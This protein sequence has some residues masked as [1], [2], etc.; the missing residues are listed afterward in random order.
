[1]S[2]RRPLAVEAP[3]K[4]NRELRVGPRRADGFHDIRSRFASIA[5]ADRIEAEEGG[6]LELYCDTPGIPTDGT[7]LV[8]RAALGLADRLGVAPRAR[9]RLTK[10]VPAGAGLGGG[11]SDAAA[12]LRL[13]SRLW[14]RTLPEAEISLLAASL[15]SDVPYFLSGGEA[16][17]SG[18]GETVA[19]RADAT[20]RDLLL[21]V[22]PFPISTAEVY[23]A[24]DRLGGA[25]P[26]P[27]LEIEGS[28]SGRFFGPNDL[29]S[30]IVAVRPEMR[31]YLETGRS[32][33][34]ECAVTGSGST[35]VLAGAE[36]DAAAEIA[37]RHPEALVLPSRTISREEF[38]ARSQ[39]GDAPAAKA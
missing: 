20:P 33:A 38:R 22:P 32:V 39:G 26:P 13:L 34:R 8:L 2:G 1:M 12:T 15:G 23:A 35:V 36:P 3:A 10:R 37:R 5:L 7:N 25:P 19:E 6:T 9:L 28:G 27:R 24:F 30:A 18:R 4:V 29:E 14:G 21:V 11:S 17:V 16:D 31:D